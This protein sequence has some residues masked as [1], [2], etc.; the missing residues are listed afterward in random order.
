MFIQCNS[1]ALNNHTIHPKWWLPSNH[2]PLTITIPIPEE[3]I[4]TCKNNIK[5]DS[6]KETQFLEDTV[7]I[8]KNLNV[9]SLMDIYMLENIINELAI[10][11]KEI[12]NQNTKP[13]NITKHSNSWWDNNYSRELKKYKISKS[14]EN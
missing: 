9:L 13:T 14:L 2:T 8:F 12:W 10:N 11:V 6:N 4:I 5:K 3:V 7:N 1:P